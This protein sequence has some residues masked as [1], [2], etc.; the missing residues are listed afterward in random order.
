[1]IR[2]IR[3][4]V[5]SV[6]TVFTFINL[7]FIS[8]TFIRKKIVCKKNGYEKKY[9]YAKKWLESIEKNEIYRYSYDNIRLHADYIKKEDSNSVIILVHGYHAASWLDFSTMLKFYYDNNFSILAITQR[10]HGKSE[11]NLI[12]FG[13]KEEKDLRMWVNFLIEESF[14]KI[15][16]HGVS[17]GASTS[18]IASSNLP[19]NVKC[20]IADCGYTTAVEEMSY[21]LNSQKKIPSYLLIPFQKFFTKY[22]LGFDITRSTRNSLKSN[23]IP[24]LYIHG[25]KDKYVPLYMTK[26]NY[27]ITKSKKEIY[28]VDDA[29]HALSNIIDEEG[30]KDKVIS[31]IEEL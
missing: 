27:F 3:N 13:D 24:I 14:E 26:E 10:A 29:K 5:V 11:G 19:K 17:M 8:K 12:T 16:I 23:I 22:I 30:Y 28:L 15:Y 25:K 7:Y 6:M 20:I 21:V 4:L 18:L 31:F 2:K 9:L 1:M